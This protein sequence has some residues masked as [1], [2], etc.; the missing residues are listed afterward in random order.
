MDKNLPIRS[1]KS[2]ISIF[3]FL[4]I[5]VYRRCEFDLLDPFSSARN[6]DIEKGNLL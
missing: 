2:R 3:S 6:D 4:H 5:S 1:L